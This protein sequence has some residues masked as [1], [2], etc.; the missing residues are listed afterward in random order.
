MNYFFNCVT[1]LAYF[2]RKLSIILYYIFDFVILSDVLAIKILDLFYPVFASF[3]SFSSKNIFSHIFS[4][5]G[6]GIA[7]FKSTS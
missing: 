5:I 1:L 3:A 6:V 4:W 7:K 2:K